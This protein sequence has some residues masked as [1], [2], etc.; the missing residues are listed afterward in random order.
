M[1]APLDQPLAN[2]CILVVEDM[3]DELRLLARA[4][5][6]AG[7]RVLTAVDGSEALRLAQLMRPDAVVM[8]VRLPPPDGFIVCRAL[9]ALPESA[10][11]PVVFISGL[12]D[13]PAKLAAFAA[14]GRDYLTKPFS[15]AELIARVA[16]HAQLGRRLRAGQLDASMPRWLSLCIQSLHTALAEPPSLELLAQ[17]VGSTVHGIQEGFRIHLQTTPA[18]FVREARL[19]EAARQLHETATPVA[20]VGAALGY[21][22]PANFATAFKERFGVSPRQHRQ[23]SKTSSETDGPAW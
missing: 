13:V 21:P 17:E 3:P 8:D 12:L 2:L 7:A 9:L 10:E 14:G 15:D 23:G 4:L 5:G 20:E 19:T 18:A 11:L 22:N 1:T 16:L 6:E